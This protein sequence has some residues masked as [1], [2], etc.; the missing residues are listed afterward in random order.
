MSLVFVLGK[1]LTFWG[2]RRE[3]ERERER[4][5]RER[6]RERKR[7]RAGGRARP[8]QLSLSAC[9]YTHIAR[10]RGEKGDIGEI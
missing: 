7:E 10:E 8:A 9:I 4:E 5:E 6:E 1:I 3:R 2:K